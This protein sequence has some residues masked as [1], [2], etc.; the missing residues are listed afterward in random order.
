MMLSIHIKMNRL[1]PIILVALIAGSCQGRGSVATPTTL[2]PTTTTAKPTVTHTPQPTPTFTPAAFQPMAV[3]AA[4][5]EYGGKFKSIETVD[6]Y[7]V[8]FTLCSPEPAFLVKLAS[9]A[10][11]IQP[12]EYLEQT[13][14]GGDGSQ[15]L[16]KPIGAGPYRVAEWSRGKQLVLNAFADYWGEKP[17]AT[18]LVFRWQVNT[19]DR[20]LELQA[21]SVDGI[22][23][24]SPSDYASVSGDRNLKLFTR[25]A[26]NIFYLGINSTV[27]PFDNEDV[28][29]AVALA[30]DRK[31]IV[32]NYFQPG[33]EEAAYFTPCVVPNGCAGEAWYALN[34]VR[35]KELLTIL[36]LQEG[37]NAALAY[38]NIPSLYLAQPKMVAQEIQ[39]QLLQNLKIKL[40]LKEMAPGDFNQ[41]ALTGQLPGLFL[42]S[43]EAVYPD[44][45]DF[46]DPNFGIGA[47]LLFGNKFDD[48][49]SALQS[50]ASLTGDEARR[51]YYEA[52]NNAIRQHYLMVPIAHGGTAVSFLKSV[53]GAHASPMRLEAFAKMSVAGQ[54]TLTW[55][56]VAEPA[57]L[58]CADEVDSDSLRAC[59]QVVESLY[60]YQAGKA[61]V[62]PALAETCVPNANLTV[63]T[64]RLRQGVLFHDG[65]TL[66][67]GDVVM[68]FVIQWDASSPFHKGV[69]YYWN[70]LWG[71]FLNNHQ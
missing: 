71:Q 45:T 68:S 59:S 42:S 58:Y 6:Q 36:W 22:D 24:V 56:Q 67:A 27:V 60:R 8:R 26:L 53:E 7:T 34:F 41:A 9:P 37:F 39:R 3:S 63:W 70:L 18:S 57:S 50:G 14:G 29:H 11:G 33:S 28:R 51:P 2:L 17:K 40:G 10:F 16:E 46:L 5:C 43:W 54:D 25:P 15:L 31:Q 48:I 66:D 32:L 65:S 62:E 12:R 23:A 61:T 30:L 4:D 20:L 38:L 35:A 13:G 55:M 52:A 44:M 49:T 19:A 64:C 47:P 69:Y 1:T 21:G